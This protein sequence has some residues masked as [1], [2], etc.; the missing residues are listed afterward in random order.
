MMYCA[1]ST[2]EIARACLWIKA[3]VDS[4]ADLS[5]WLALC[6]DRNGLDR[7]NVIGWAVD[8]NFSKWVVIN[9]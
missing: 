9:E 2:H 8:F 7:K 6:K 5:V 3:D 1:S 4:A